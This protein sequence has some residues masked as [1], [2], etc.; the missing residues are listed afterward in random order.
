M[1]RTYKPGAHPACAPRLAH[2]APL[3]PQHSCYMTS[4]LPAAGM[5]HALPELLWCN[6]LPLVSMLDSVWDPATKAHS[7]CSKW[8]PRDWDSHRCSDGRHTAEQVRQAKGKCNI[9]FVLRVSTW[10]AVS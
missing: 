3:Q 5:R 9:P 8:V 1:C 2:Y 10:A 4:V 6:R 7:T